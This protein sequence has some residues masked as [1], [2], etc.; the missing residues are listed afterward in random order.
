MNRRESMLARWQDEQ[1]RIA[2]R[3]VL[4]RACAAA[5]RVNRRPITY[6]CRQCRRS[7]I[8][9]HRCNRRKGAA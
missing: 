9:W 4:E 5:A 3:P 7:Y 6:Y 1:Y 8:R 2:M